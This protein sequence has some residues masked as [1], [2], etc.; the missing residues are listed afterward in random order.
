VSAQLF[1]HGKS[2]LGTPINTAFFNE[3]LN[4]FSCY[5]NTFFSNEK[6]K[7]VPKLMRT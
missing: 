1:S 5:E 2:P 3:R 6:Q 7:K 4:V